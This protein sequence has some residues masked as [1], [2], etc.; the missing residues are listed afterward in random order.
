M[1]AGSTTNAELLLKIFSDSW[2]EQLLN[3]A[4]VFNFSAWNHPGALG[5]LLGAFLMNQVGS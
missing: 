2:K 3:D 4:A 5:A 1:N